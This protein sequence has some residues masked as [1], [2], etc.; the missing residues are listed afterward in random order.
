MSNKIRWIDDSVL[1]PTH[2]FDLIGGIGVEES[3][4]CDAENVRL[5]I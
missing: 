3:I 2:Y 5:F 4:F 1:F